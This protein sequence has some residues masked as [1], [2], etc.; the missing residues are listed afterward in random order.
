MRRESFFSPFVLQPSL[1]P[2]SLSISSLTPQMDTAIR[3]GTTQGNNAITLLPLSIEGKGGEQV[4]LLL[5]IHAHPREANV[6][7]EE[8]SA[9]AEHALLESEGESWHRMDSALKELNGLFKG[10]LA[11]QA[12]SDIHAV[13]AFIDKEGTIH[14]S[15][16]GRGEAY[17]V[18]GTSAS[19]ITE[20]VKGK[21]VPMFVHISS[22]E[23]E[24][25]DAV[26]FSTQRLLR[27]FT[28]AQLSQLLTVG[29]HD[30]I[31]E[32]V[33]RL[34]SEREMAA[35][36]IVTVPQG[37]RAAAAEHTPTPV[38]SAPA[39]R[40]HAKTGYFAP[41]L[42]IAESGLDIAMSG[43]KKAVAS[44]SKGGSAAGLGKRLSNLG[45][46]FE[47]FVADLRHPERK[48]RAHMLLIAS[49]LSAFLAVWVLVQLTAVTQ[50]SKT[51]SQITEM[52]TQI[53]EELRTA[54][55]KRIIG[56]MEGASA[57]LVRAEEQAKQILSN[58]SGLYRSE[59]LNILDRIRAKKE[60][61]LNVTRVSPR[62]VVNIATKNPSVTAAGLIGIADGE[63]SVYDRDHLYHVLLNTVEEGRPVGDND[64][65]VDGALLARFKSQVFLT[66]GSS[67]IEVQ[68]GQSTVMKTEDAGGWVAGKDIETYLR[69]LYIL[70][71]DNRIEKYERLSN[72]YG[73]AS[74]YNVSGDLTGSIDMVIDGNVF[75][76]KEKGKVVK[77]FRGE[78][79]PFSMHNVP[80]GALD[81]VTKFTKLPNGNFY[82]LDPS[83]KQVLVATD[84]G[85]TGES[86]YVRQY[87]FEGEIGNLKD[88]YVDPDETHLYIMDE[89]RVYVADIVKK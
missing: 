54:D 64:A 73:P 35:L 34:E 81:G 79:Q 66:N 44:V 7:R 40:R 9:I 86:T 12:I 28:P 13:L 33:L 58:D 10:F 2:F 49:A 87:V 80:E 15:H 65:I 51:R 85:S 47:N 14:V 63:F 17:L 83:K 1:L 16:A 32:I 19:Q 53:E 31:Q 38:R 70:T 74:P 6:L 55:N 24:T 46:K 3:T 42:S 88:L 69:Y 37:R 82:F 76:L 77:L 89:Q 84:G 57:V 71:P 21:P 5:Q 39:R 61:I 60:E 72:R 27:T 22:G 26:I 59:A 62:L 36:A 23:L 11:S 52:M 25:G 50:S 30:A 29:S 48:R 56:D 68:S 45:D 8:T 20:Y 67:V 75:V 43:A 78:A 41:L 18:R 4:I